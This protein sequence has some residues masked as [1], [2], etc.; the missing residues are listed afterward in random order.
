MCARKSC[1]RARIYEIYVC[2][3]HTTYTH[4]E[5]ISLV[6][7]YL[8]LL[9]Y[10]LHNT[11]CFVSNFSIC[12]YTNTL[13]IQSIGDKN[14]VNFLS[15]GNDARWLVILTIKAIFEFVQRNQGGQW[16]ENTQITCMFLSE[17]SNGTFRLQIIILSNIVQHLNTN[18]AEK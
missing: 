4:N 14:K 16:L 18:I 15:T 8:F 2:L 13:F 6:L 5:H 10:L 3:M 12:R 17:E 11:F 9:Y 1:V 7:I